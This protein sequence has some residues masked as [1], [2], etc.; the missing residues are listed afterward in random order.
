MSGQVSCLEH[1]GPNGDAQLYWEMEEGP[2]T[3]GN[4]VLIS[5]PREL[6]WSKST[7]V[8][9]DEKVGSG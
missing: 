6:L 1:L 7:V 3:V 5:S 8:N 2:F 4:Q 9:V